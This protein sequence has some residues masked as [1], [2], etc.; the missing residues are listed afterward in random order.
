MDIKTRQVIREDKE[1]ILD[2]LRDEIGRQYAE[3]INWEIDDVIYKRR[4]ARGIVMINPE[5]IG[6]ASWRKR[7]ESICLETIGIRRELLKK[8]IEF[9]KVDF[10]NAQMIN[11]VTDADAR[12]NISFYAK[13]GFEASGIVNDEFIYGTPQIHMS[14]KI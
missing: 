10:P 11:L 8:A 5:I 1:I 4:N 6:Y 9:A 7:V 14:L 3:E 12:R 13:N 2:I